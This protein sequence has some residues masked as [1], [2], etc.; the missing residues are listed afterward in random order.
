M[1]DVVILQEY[2]TRLAQ[3]DSFICEKSQPYADKL[4]REIRSGSPDALIQ[5]YQT[6]GRPY[7]LADDCETNPFVC[8]YG[9]MQDRLTENYG[10]LACMYKPSQVAP[11]SKHGN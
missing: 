3:N 5:F 11:V 9:I 6:W 8:E 7:G 10:N 4:I 1:W 2:S